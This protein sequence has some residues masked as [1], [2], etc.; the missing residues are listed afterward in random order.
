MCDDRS[1][2][3]ILFTPEAEAYFISVCK[4]Q[5][6]LKLLHLGLLYNSMREIDSH[7]WM[8]RES[9]SGIAIGQGG[10][11]TPLDSEKFAK[12]REKSGKRGEK[13]GKRG[14]TIGEGSYTLP[15]LTDSAGYATGITAL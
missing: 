7:I 10:Q 14:K 13:S 4:N 15:L 9:L 3:T 6:S 5:T 1:Y 12:K 2:K 8:L 11:S